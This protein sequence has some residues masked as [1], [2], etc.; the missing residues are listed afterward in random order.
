MLHVC[1]D[2]VR[3]ARGVSAVEVSPCQR[4]AQADREA[5]LAAV[6]RPFPEGLEGRGELTSGVS[7]WYIDKLKC[8][9]GVVLGRPA[10]EGRAIR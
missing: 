1:L 8:V 5:R 10:L 3:G 9:D 7:I 6:E 2:Y 4:E